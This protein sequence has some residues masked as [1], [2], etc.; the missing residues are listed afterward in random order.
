[1]PATS[2][3]CHSRSTAGQRGL[4][5][6][7]SLEQATLEGCTL[8][9]IDAEAIGTAQA[10]RDTSRSSFQTW[11]SASGRKWAI[12]STSNTLLHASVFRPAP[13]FPNLSCSAVRPAGVSI[14][15]HAA[16]CRSE[17]EPRRR[18]MRRNMCHAVLRFPRD[19]PAPGGPGQARMAPGA[20]RAA[21]QRRRR[22]SG[23]RHDAKAR[24]W[25]EV[26]RLSVS[27]WGALAR[28]DQRFPFFHGRRTSQRVSQPDGFA[29][30]LLPLKGK[31]AFL[32][33]YVRHDATRAML[34]NVAAAATWVDEDLIAG[35]DSGQLSYAALDALWPSRCAE[36]RFAASKV[37]GD[38]ARGA[39]RIRRP[40][41]TE[42]PTS[43][44]W[45]L[46]A[47]PAGSRHHHGV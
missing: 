18:S 9:L 22:L 3:H 16:K 40:L 28:Q 17:G 5:A 44:A 29:V 43:R 27:A 32:C 21:E 31:E 11:K 46:A 1:M 20:D 37:I 25:C 2:R 13:A 34:V 39:A 35:S 19:S 10:W 47:S 12:W 36:S 7:P 30:C 6:R 26:A 38:A 4:R 23:L 15:L 24:R 8:L 45:R 14:R 41:A 33:A 42:I